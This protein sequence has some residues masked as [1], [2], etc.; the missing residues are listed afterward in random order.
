MLSDEDFIAAQKALKVKGQ[1]QLT[2]EERKQRQR[3]LD[4]LGS[5]STVED[6]LRF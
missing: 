3:A 6:M 5:K 1:Q 2:K 4:N